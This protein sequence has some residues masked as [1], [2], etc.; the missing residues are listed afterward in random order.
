MTD[1]YIIFNNLKI[2]Y[3]IY[4]FGTEEEQKAAEQK[5]R[6][7]AEELKKI[8]FAPNFCAAEYIEKNGSRHILHHSTRPGVLYQLSYIAPDGIPT[9]HQNIKEDNTK[10]LINHFI[11]YNCRH[12]LKLHIITA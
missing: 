1:N 7:R 3:N 10:E 4:F 9:S 8:F 5:E 12:S 6:E 2:D 11:F